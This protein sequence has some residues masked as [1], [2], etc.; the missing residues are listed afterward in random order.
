MTEAS[1]SMSFQGVSGPISRQLIIQLFHA[2]FKPFGLVLLCLT[3]I[4]FTIIYMDTTH[5]CPFSDTLF[6]FTDIRLLFGSHGWYG[7]NLQQLKFL[8]SVEF[9]ISEIQLCITIQIKIVQTKEKTAARV[10][11]LKILWKKK[12]HKR[13]NELGL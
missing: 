9:I 11:K 2:I 8:F 6:H 3:L 7:Q 12:K 10:P 5:L 1:T 4:Q 13:R